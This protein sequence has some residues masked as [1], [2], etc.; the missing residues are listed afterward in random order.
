ME[1]S[2][3]PKRYRVQMRY[4]AEDWAIVEAHNRQQ[5]IERAYDASV[6]QVEGEDWI[7]EVGSEVVQ[8]YQPVVKLAILPGKDQKKGDT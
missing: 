1:R 3:I 7:I 2:L 6:T 8:H 4:L 5:A